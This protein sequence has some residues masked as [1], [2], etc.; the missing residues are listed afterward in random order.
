M[1]ILQLGYETYKAKKVIASR[2]ISY[3]FTNLIA[4]D[5][6]SLSELR[7][8][9]MVRGAHAQNHMTTS[10]SFAGSTR[11]QRRRTKWLFSSISRSKVCSLTPTHPHR[12]DGQNGSGRSLLMARDSRSTPSHCTRLP[13]PTAST[14]ATSRPGGT[15]RPSRPC[16]FLR[17]AS[18]S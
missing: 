14:G 6:Y 4:N 7:R 16:C 5:Y 11:R 15:T 10:A 12:A 9:K 3:A 18:P 8:I 1:L 17:S 13:M 2:D